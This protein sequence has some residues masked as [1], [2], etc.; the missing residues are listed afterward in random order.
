MDDVNPQVLKVRIEAGGNGVMSDL[1]LDNK[2][3]G[4][5]KEA[6]TAL[7]NAVRGRIQDSAGPTAAAEL[8]EV[9]FDCDYELS[10]D[11]VIRAIDAISGYKTGSGDSQR[12]QRLIEKVRF[13]KPR[14]PRR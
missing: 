9:E 7:R 1:K 6:F 11:Y 12:I 10:Y 3:L 14:P 13:A 4:N 5:G 2:S 8:M